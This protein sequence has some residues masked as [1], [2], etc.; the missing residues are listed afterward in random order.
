[1]ERCE[2]HGTILHDR[3]LMCGAPQC[4]VDCCKEALDQH[5][6]QMESDQGERDE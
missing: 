3:C 4:C 6:E 1:M 5:I 2:T